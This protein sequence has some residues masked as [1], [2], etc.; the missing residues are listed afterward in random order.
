MRF[1]RGEVADGKAAASLLAAVGKTIRGFESLPSP[2]LL[3]FQNQP[4]GEQS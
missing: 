3:I 2:P 1:T 4:Q